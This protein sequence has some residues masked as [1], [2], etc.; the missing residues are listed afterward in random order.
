MNTTLEK[1]KK[2]QAKDYITAGIFSALC[3]VVMLIAAIVNISGY[4]TAFYPT[5]AS[6]FIGIL[7][8]ILLVKVPKRGV[9]LIFGIV[10]CIYFFLSGVLEGLIGAGCVIA[11]SLIAE[12]ILSK[13]HD[14]VK[15]ITVSGVIYT[16]YLSLAGSAEHFLL[17]DTYCDNALAAGVNETVVEQMRVMFNLK[18]MWP[19]VILSTA[20]FTYFGIL[21]GRRIMKKHLKKAGIL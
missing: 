7:Y 19:I 15:Y 3:I 18:W 16:L 4:T 12:A 14:S 10:P 20:L 6:F 13:H 11:F 1:N 8:V 17:T 21:I 2:L 5:V 9:L